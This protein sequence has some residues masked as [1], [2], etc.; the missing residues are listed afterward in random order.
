MSDLAGLVYKEYIPKALKGPK[1][2]IS[3]SMHRNMIGLERQQ[4]YNT[5]LFIRLFCKWM[6]KFGYSS[7]TVEL[8]KLPGRHAE[9]MSQIEAHLNDPVLHN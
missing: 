1:S 6:N 8:N 9:S 3:N 5:I 2:Y 7:S 4:K